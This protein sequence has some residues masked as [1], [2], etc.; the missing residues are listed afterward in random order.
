MSITRALAPLALAALLTGVIGC[1]AQAICAKEQECNDK[2]QDDDPAVC[3]EA[4][5]RT[6]DTL[7]ANKEEECQTLADATLALA[8]CKAS[9]DCDDFEEADLGQKCDQE[10]KDFQHAEEDAVSG[11][12]FQ[13]GSED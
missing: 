3:A 7:R 1:T 12:Q 9:L 5:N 10:Q 11:G 8:A 2:R 6:I 13:C 4:F